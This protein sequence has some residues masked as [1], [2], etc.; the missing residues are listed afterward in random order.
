MDSQKIRAVED[1]VARSFSRI[2]GEEYAFLGPAQSVILSRLPLFQGIAER[3][4]RRMQGCDPGRAVDPWA[5]FVT[6]D[7]AHALPPMS[8]H[9]TVQLHAEPPASARL[10][11]G[12]VHGSFDPFHLGHLLMGLDAV[13]DGMCDFSVIIPNA[14]RSAGGSSEKPGKSS[15]AW[16]MRTAFEGGVDDF[17]PITRL[18]PFGSQGDAYAAYARLIG[19]NRAL[20]EG[21]DE[22]EI[23]VVIGSDIAFRPRF[24][25]W[26]NDTYGR[27]RGLLGSRAEIRFRIVERAGFTGCADRARTLDFPV[28]V[29][30][31]ISCASSSSIRLN[32]VS[33]VWLYPRAVPLLESYL[34]YGHA[35]R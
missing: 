8:R 32:P 24:T 16:R 33:A 14:D 13:A 12:I 34:R 20:L 5:G 27:I 15:H 26:T 11:L 1:A 22:V 23:V 31:E 6:G 2:E 4:R 29:V 19:E 17:F 35:E 30:P 21:L 28:T 10:S 7:G 3:I 25:E 9:R 18:S